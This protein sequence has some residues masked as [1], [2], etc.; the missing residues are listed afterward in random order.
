MNP[1]IRWHLAGALFALALT[2]PLNSAQSGSGSLF[3]AGPNHPRP[4]VSESV[5]N[6]NSAYTIIATGLRSPR[7]L[8]FAGCNRLFV[9]EAGKG[10]TAD[11]PISYTGA[12]DEILNPE[13]AS[14]VRRIV[15]GL[16]SI[17]D[18]SLGEIIGPSGLAAGRNG[19]ISTVIGESVDATGN[20][21]FGQFLDV[22]TS[23]DVEVR[24]NVGSADYLF[25][26]RHADLDPGG[27]YPDANPYAVLNLPG[28]TYAV[29]AGSNTL[30]EV[31]PNGKVKVLAYFENNITADSTP[32]CLA[33]GPDGALYVGVLALVDSLVFGPS[34]KIYRVD[35][36]TL[37]AGVIIGAAYEWATGLWP[38]NGC[39]FGPDGTF[40]ASELITSSDF[41]GGDVVKIPFD[42]P[43]THI[44]LTDQTL[45][46]AAGVAVGSDGTV[47]AVGLTAYS[48]SGFVA[49]LAER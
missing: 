31:F 33:Q 27:Q 41:S 14:S 49:R 25:T 22:T 26:L 11:N 30:D 45:P 19:V 39:A 36:T 17:G 35:P 23:G 21:G 20:A 47:Y 3:S 13:G 40:Y 29:D 32:T 16:A 2:L 43:A 48:P 15:Y 4:V 28:H 7:G 12:I 37:P 6:S 42:D 46:L 44:S 18:R 10:G 8:T 38:I 1:P 5:S 9:A 24:A 34:A